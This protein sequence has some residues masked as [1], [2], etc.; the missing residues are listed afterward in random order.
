MSI[1][2]AKYAD[3]L[4]LDQA[5][6]LAVEAIEAGIIH[7]E[8]SGSTVNVC[9]I[10]NKGAKME[11]NVKSYNKRDWYN[12]EPYKFPK[13]S[14]PYFNEYKFPKIVVEDQK[15]GDGKMVQE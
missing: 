9:V 11:M 1:F 10:T 12:P 4:T 15:D 7:D 2:E 3:N 8:G 5:R 6:A 14:T 13:G